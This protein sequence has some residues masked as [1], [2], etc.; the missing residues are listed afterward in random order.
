MITE[1]F[2]IPTKG[3]LNRKLKRRPGLKLVAVSPAFM[4]GPFCVFLI[5]EQL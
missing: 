1:R 5:Y 4:W 2:F 3:R